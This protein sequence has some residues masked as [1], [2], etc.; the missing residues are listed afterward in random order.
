MKS[1]TVRAGQTVVVEA[2][3]YAEPEPVATWLCEGTELKPDDR[4]SMSLSPKLAKLTILN[5]KR[6]ETGKYTI[7]LTNS[8]GSDNAT[9]DV[10][11]LG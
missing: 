5:S 4:I 1:I 8:S 9:C 6:S 3:F 10:I 11:V 2:P 7:R